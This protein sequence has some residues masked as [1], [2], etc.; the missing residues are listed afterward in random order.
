MKPGELENDKVDTWTAITK[1]T[2][3]AVP[4]AGPLLS[5]IVGSL[6]PNQRLDRVCEF[7]LEIEKRLSTVELEQ[8]KQNTFAID[9]FE[10]ATVIASRALTEVRNQYVA[11][12]IKSAVSTDNT[13]YDLKKRLL[14]IL[15]DLTDRDIEILQSIKEQ[16]Y[17]H[18]ASNYYPGHIT[19]GA[20]NNL[21]EHEKME[22]HSM[23]EVWPLHISTLERFGLLKAHREEQDVDNTHGHIDS[24]TGL[25]RINYYEITKLGDI[26]LSSI[27]SEQ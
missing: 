24:D 20:F 11:S 12:F 9:L 14:Y 17:K 22:Y 16:G 21:S 1:G 15:Q 3:G 8:L 10:D 7:L 5:E 19:A 27:S 2:F 13:E 6:I 23:H 4:I 26:F 18:T 25:P